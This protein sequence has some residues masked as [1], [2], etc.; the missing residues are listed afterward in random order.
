MKN[1]YFIRHGEAIN[2]LKDN[3]LVG[4]HFDAA[5]TK[6]GILQ[7]QQAAKEIKEKNLKFDVILSSPLQRAADTASIISEVVGYPQSEIEYLD[8][9][10]ER[11]FGELAGKPF[12]EALGMTMAD[13]LA[14]P[15]SADHLDGVE[16]LLNLHHRAESLTELLKSRTEDSILIVSHGALGRS[17]RKVIEGKAFDEEV[18]KIPNAKIIKLL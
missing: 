16:S 7:A 8:I 5:L 15:L 9:L 3:E 17:I 1:L 14:N 10:K 13:Y 6:K 18:D 4:G 2:N 11:D 12:E